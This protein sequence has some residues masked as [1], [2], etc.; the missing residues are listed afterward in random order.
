MRTI[1]NI[2][3]NIDRLLGKVVILKKSF[4]AYEVVGVERVS[5]FEQYFIC[6][7]LSR[8]YGMSH[9]VDILDDN[10]LTI[11]AAKKIYSSLDMVRNF[12]S[13]NKI[14]EDVKAINIAGVMY[15]LEHAIEEAEQYGN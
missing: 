13:E 6:R 10:I 2:N 5:D 12:V 7:P 1:E 15:R 9:Y 8:I 14:E 3:K 11:E 4:V